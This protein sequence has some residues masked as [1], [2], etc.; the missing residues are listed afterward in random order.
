MNP[1]LSFDCS[2][3]ESDV[4]YIDRSST[5]GVPARTNTPAV[6]NSTQLSGAVARETITISSVASLEP[7][8]VTIY[9]DSRELT[10]PYGFGNQLPIAPPSLNDL[11]LT[12]NQFNVLATLAVIRS[13]DEYSPQSPEASIS[14]PISTPP[15]NLGATEGWA[16]MHTT[17]DDNTFY[18]EVEPRRVSWD[19]SPS[20]IF[21][22]NDPRYVFFASRP[23]STPLLPRQRKR[24]LSMV[25]CFFKTGECPSTTVRHA[26]SPYHQ[27]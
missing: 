21:D 16:T 1:L 23:S 9:S 7:Q 6:F 14:S 2:S 25:I 3:T 18:S 26:A 10:I 13:D 20:E 11:N 8:I 19:S 5:E 4:F 24:K 15:M 27:E 22:S 12:P 17:T